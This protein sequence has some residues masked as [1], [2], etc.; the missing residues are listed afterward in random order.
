MRREEKE[1]IAGEEKPFES[2]H[3]STLLELSDGS[4][5]AAWFGGSW[6]KAPDTAIWTAI[7]KNGM[8]TQ[9]K[10]TACHRGTACWN[11]VLFRGADGR[12]LLFYK[13]G[14]EIVTWKTYCTESFDEGENFGMPYELVEGDKS[15]GRGPVKNKPIRLKDGT[16]L[17]G[18]SLEGEVWDAFADRSQDDAKTW[19][20]SGLV[21]LR[22]VSYQLES[23]HTPYSRYACY[24]KGIIQPT[25]WEDSQGD[26]HMLCRST[27]SRIFRSDSTD[28]GKTWGLAYDCGLPNNNSG[29]DLV[30]MKDGRLVLACNPRENAPNY[31]KGARTPLVLLLSKDNGISWEELAVIEK[32]RGHY[33][34]PAV[35][36]CENGDICVTY[37]WNRRTIGFYRLH[38]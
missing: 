10:L 34:Y 9:P 8:W 7:R 22:R 23:L 13:V 32:D 17:A 4:I 20:R 31:Y 26:V 2:A 6:E 1:W 3:A 5:L 30:C 14:A 38:F 19:T 36:C 11:P 33:S 16:V 18:G 28:G 24:G 37:T 25:L 21:P 29:I 15:G 35:I 12:I 27:S